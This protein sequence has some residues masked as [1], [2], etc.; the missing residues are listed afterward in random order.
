[1]FK[2]TFVIGLLLGLID[3]HVRADDDFEDEFDIQEDA[4]PA[5][6][7]Q[8][9]LEKGFGHGKRHRKGRG[10]NKKKRENSPDNKHKKGENQEDEKA[11]CYRQH[12]YDIPPE[13]SAAEH[14]KRIGKAQNR[15]YDCGKKLTDIEARLYLEVNPKIKTGKNRFA[16]SSLR[17]ARSDYSKSGRLDKAFQH[18]RDA[19]AEPFLCSKENQVCQCAGTVHFGF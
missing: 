19:D 1:M 4:T 7:T 16:E 3:T 2:K 18:L 13:L 10:H 9:L 15:F 5:N 12:Y 17:S 6:G 8:A 11:R 14:Y